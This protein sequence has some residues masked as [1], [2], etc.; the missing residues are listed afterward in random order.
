MALGEGYM[1]DCAELKIS[2][3]NLEHLG[4]CWRK[5]EDCNMPSKRKIVR[6]WKCKCKMIPI[7]SDL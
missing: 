1:Y 4:D 3:I 6:P 7:A 5:A 2:W